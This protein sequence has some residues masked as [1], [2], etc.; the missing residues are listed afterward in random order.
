MN[1]QIHSLRKNVPCLLSKKRADCCEVSF[2]GDESLQRVFLSWQ[3]LR[4]LAEVKFRGYSVDEVEEKEKPD[5]KSEPSQPIV[6]TMKARE[7][8]QARSVNDGHR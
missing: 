3:S 2:E 7:R 1:V 8:T 5:G 6:E 4:S